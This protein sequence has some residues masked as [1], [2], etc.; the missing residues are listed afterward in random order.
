MKTP[1]TL[2]KGEST[3][4]N[5][6]GAICGGVVSHST[7]HSDPWAYMMAYVMSDENFEIYKTLT[8]K[9]M[10]HDFFKKYARSMI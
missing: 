9:K 2:E 3:F 4:R 7:F 1:K 5:G 8:N 10:A 6:G